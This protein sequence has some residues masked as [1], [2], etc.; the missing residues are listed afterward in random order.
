[1]RT[2]HSLLVVASIREWSITQL[3]VENAFLNGKLSEVVYMQ[4]P[5]GYSIYEGMVYH[6]CRSLYGLKQDPRAWL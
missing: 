1:M 4:P 5:S 3:D 2:I 6:L